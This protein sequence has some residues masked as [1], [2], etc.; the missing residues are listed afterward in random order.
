M[1]PSPPKRPTPIFFWNAMPIETPLAAQRKE[2]FWQ[3]SSPPLARTPAREHRHEQAL[4]GQDAL[5]RPDERA[6]DAARLLPAAVAEDRFHLDAGRHVHHHAGLGHRALPGVEL[7]LHELHVAAVDL[8]VDVAPAAPGRRRDGARRRRRRRQVR[9]ELRHVADGGPVLH[10]LREHER[11]WIEAPVPDVGEDLV[12]A[13]RSDLMAAD[14]QP[15]LLGRHGMRSRVRD[16]PRESPGTRRRSARPRRATPRARP[17]RCDAR[18]P[19]RGG[20]WPPDRDRADRRAGP[21]TPARCR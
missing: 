3:T 10:A 15:P 18:P 12:L 17:R 2:S 14:G 21:G 8:E 5:A 7:D 9:L 11:A 13:D 1:K 16:G 4:A 20:R 19:L 6:H